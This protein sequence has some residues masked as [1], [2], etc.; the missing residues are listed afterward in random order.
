MAW[1]LTSAD[2]NPTPGSGTPGDAGGTIEDAMARNVV[3]AK[4]DDM[5]AWG[6]KN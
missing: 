6:R 3:T 5:I 2:K 1:S 4:L